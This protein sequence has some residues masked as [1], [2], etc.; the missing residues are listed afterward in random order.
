MSE[1]TVAIIKPD[2]VES[3]WIGD[4][5]KDASLA[6]L[7]PVYMLMRW[8]DRKVW[9]EFYAEHAIKPFYDGL[10]A[11][12]SSGPCVLLA[13]AGPS[14]ISRWRQIMGAT[15]PLKA[16]PGSIRRKWGRGGPAN[17]V[18][19]SDSRESVT[20]EAAILGVSVEERC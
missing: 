10:I 13:L 15:D 2:A 5:L 16:S 9:E 18:H 6:E 14:A 4:I 7:Y 1:W 8:V 19:G 11:H 20:R 17:A 12:M 3:G